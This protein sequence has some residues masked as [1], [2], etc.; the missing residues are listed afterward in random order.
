[1]G[2]IAGISGVTAVTGICALLR[3]H[4][5]EM[6]VALA[7]LLVILFVSA[8]W[9]RWPGLAASVV[10]MLLL[11]YYFLPPLYTLTIEDPKNWIALGAF[12]ITAFTAG[13]LSSWAKQRAA[14]AEASQSQARLASTYNRSLLE[15]IVDPLLSIGPDGRVNDV[16]AGA[17]TVTGRSRAELIGTDFAEYFREPGKSRAAYE[18]VFRGGALRG[19]AMEMRHR[20]GHNT[21]VLCDA[22]L[23]R[24]AGGNV[25]GVVVAM[26]PISTYVGKP[27]VVPP[28]PRV[29]RHLSLLTGFASLFCFAT[30][31]LSLAGII[32]RI[33][34]LKSII[35]GHP[36]IKM[37]AAVCLILLGLSLW[38]VRKDNQGHRGMLCGHFMAAIHRFGG[39]AQ[40]DRVHHRPGPGYRSSAVP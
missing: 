31:L 1:M 8:V 5:N 40:P 3:E 23:Y 14:E 15:A 33:A 39:S 9:G 2:Y 38:L 30:G 20:D 34:V 27:L 28:D 12:F 6:T 19:Y 4:I 7:M 10:G 32:F 26:H 22:S 21:S 13:H 35:P 24:D 29:V 18:E 11:N 17:E 37:N 25:I 36:V 16:N